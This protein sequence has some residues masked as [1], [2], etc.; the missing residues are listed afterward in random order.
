MSSHPAEVSSVSSSTLARLC[1]SGTKGTSSGISRSRA[2]KPTRTPPSDSRLASSVA[3]TM[4]RSRVKRDEP[5]RIIAIPPTTTKSTPAATSRRNIF[6]TSRSGHSAGSRS[7]G[8]TAFPDRRRQ[9]PQVVVR[10]GEVTEA[11]GRGHP[12]VGRRHRLVDLWRVGD[13]RERQLLSGR[14]DRLVQRVK[15]GV[16]ARRLQPR[17]GGLG[18]LETAR[19][20]GLAESGVLARIPDQAC[21]WA[22]ASQYSDIAYKLCP[23][24]WETLYRPS[25]SRTSSG[26]GVFSRVP[27]SIRTWCSS[28]SAA[29]RSLRS[30]VASVRIALV[31]ISAIERQTSNSSSNRSGAR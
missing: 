31:R 1:A 13:Y 21:G 10:S 29:V 19:E 14:G 2:F 24:H 4:S 12:Q 8:S 23:L 20:L 18:R 26:I 30:T 22:H 9:A 15:T 27:G 11:F 7:L 5:R 3:K 17:D 25:A 28:P 6:L 16:R